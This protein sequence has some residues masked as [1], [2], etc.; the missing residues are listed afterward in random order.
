MDND[1]KFTTQEMTDEQLDTDYSSNSKLPKPPKPG[2]LMICQFCCNPIYPEE[3]SKDKTIRKRELKWHY[4]NK[5]LNGIH[6]KTDYNTKD[7]WRERYGKNDSF[8]NLVAKELKKIID[9]KRKN[10]K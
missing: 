9:E 5:C 7:I 10:K 4:H 1:L 2:E 3:L 6:A 8:H